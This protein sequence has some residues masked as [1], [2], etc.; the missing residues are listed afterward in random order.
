[1]HI[2]DGLLDPA[3]CVGAAVISASAVGYALQRV[4]KDLPQQAVPLLGVMS[5]CVFAGQ[6]LN[7]PVPG[8]T[9]GHILGGVL[10]SVMLGPWAGMLVMTVVLVVQSVLFQDGGITALGVNVLNVAIVGP[11]AGYAL[12]DLVRRGIGGLSGALAGAVIS[13]WFAVMAAA[14]LCSLEITLGGQFRL[15]PT[16]GAM[17]LI[18]G[19]IGMGEALVTGFAVSFVLRVRPD[20]IYGDGGAKGTIARSSQLVAAGLTIA[21]VM[22]AIGSPFASAL[23]DGL[24][25]SLAKLGFQSEPAHAPAW[26][27]PLADYSVPALEHMAMAGSAAG[28][29]GTVVVFGVAVMLAWRLPRR[30]AETH[31]RTQVGGRW[32]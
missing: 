21:L 32:L 24:E 26:S 6:M 15:P 31:L 18:H 1:M 27:A 3:T 16:L 23:P 4:R 12:Y 29:I 30:E 19:L 22:A 14:T 13:S 9:S 25:A 11:V 28:V 17:L 20:L 8:G 7:F 2:P 10:A 5:A